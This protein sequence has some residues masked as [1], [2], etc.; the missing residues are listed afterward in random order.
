MEDEM[1]GRD[2]AFPEI[3]KIVLLTFS[4]SLKM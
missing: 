1:L 2:D 3:M 4:L